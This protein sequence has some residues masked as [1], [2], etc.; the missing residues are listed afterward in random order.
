ME[1]TTTKY[2]NINQ[3]TRRAVANEIHQIL[4][5][6]H[7]DSIPLDDIQ[8]GLEAHG[9]TLLQEDGTKWAGW[10]LGNCSYCLFEL[11]DLTRSEKI[12]GEKVYA[13]VKNA[14]LSL[15]WYFVRTDRIEVIGYIS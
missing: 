5:P 15:S 7:F 8:N 2:G 4:K 13:P 3:K 6:T 10:L 11:G 1:T 9:L 14:G 12:N